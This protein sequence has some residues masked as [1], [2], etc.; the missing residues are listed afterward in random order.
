LLRIFYQSE[1]FIYTHFKILLSDVMKK[2]LKKIAKKALAKLP[3]EKSFRFN[4]SIN[5]P[6]GMIARSLK[7][8]MDDLKKVNLSSIEFHVSRG[9]FSNWISDSLKDSVLARNLKRLKNLKGEQLRKRMIQIVESRYIAL[10]KSLQSTKAKIKK[11]KV[12]IKKVT[13]KKMKKKTKKKKPKKVSKKK[14][15]KRKKKRKK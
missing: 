14:K 1:N 13:K 9:D 15:V 10:S 3:D 12:K 7:E 4:T 6:T 8:F 11:T 5:K 2:T